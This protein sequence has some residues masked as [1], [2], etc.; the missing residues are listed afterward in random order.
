MQLNQKLPGVYLSFSCVFNTPLTLVVKAQLLCLSLY[1]CLSREGGALRDTVERVTRVLTTGVTR[2]SLHFTEV[3]E[4]HKASGG[5]YEGGR[6]A[7]GVEVR[8]GVDSCAV[9]KTANLQN[10]RQRSE[11]TDAFFKLKKRNL[12]FYAFRGMN[13]FCAAS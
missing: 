13:D 10:Q 6:M 1:C 4:S 2:G 3:Q 7:A 8:D 9:L 11:C 12:C 5:I